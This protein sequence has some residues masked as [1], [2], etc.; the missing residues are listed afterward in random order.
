MGIPFNV[1]EGEIKTDETVVSDLINRNVIRDTYEEAESLLT[2]SE[3][4]F[5]GW[6][7]TAKASMATEHRTKLDVDQVRFVASRTIKL[8]F[9]GW[10]QAPKFNDFAK[11]TLC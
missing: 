5:D 2:N 9:E 10:K 8:G 4:S 1:D 3:V 7:A 6:G 11:K